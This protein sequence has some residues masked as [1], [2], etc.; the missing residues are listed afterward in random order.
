MDLTSKDPTP[1]PPLDDDGSQTLFPVIPQ[2]ATPPPQVSPARIP[3]PSAGPS[4]PKLLLPPGD[5]EA[6]I[7]QEVREEVRKAVE[8]LR[9]DIQKVMNREN[10]PP[11]PPREASPLG[12]YNIGNG[13]MTGQPQPVNITIN[14]TKRGIKSYKNGP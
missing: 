12:R 11:P 4:T 5:T 14:T 7:R 2:P 9:Q 6:S 3:I 10:I 1:E 13:N 8:I